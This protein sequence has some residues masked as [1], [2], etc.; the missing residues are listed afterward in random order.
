MSNQRPSTSPELR[1][2]SSRIETVAFDEHGVCHACRY[3]EIKANTNWLARE[4]QLNEL[5]NRHRRTDG[6]YDVIVPGSGGKDSAFVSHVLKHK[7]GMNPL[8]VTWAPHMY[9]D[10]GWKNFQNWLRKGGFDNYLVTP[11]PKVHATLTKL[12]FLNILNPFQPFIIGQKN[13]APRIALHYGIKLIMYG[14]NQAEYH[15]K[16]SETVTPLM[17]RAHYTGRPGE[18]FY[19]GGVH[20]DELPRYGITARDLEPYLPISTEAAERAGIEI[21][22]MSYYHRWVP[23]E[24]FYYAAEHCGFE[25][26]PE[27]SEGTYS[28][29]ASLDDRIDG[30]HYYTMF[31]KFGQGRAM[32]DAAHEIRD[33]HITRE[34]GVALVRK[35][36]GEFPKKYFAE[37]LEYTELTEEEFWGAIDR[38][39]SPHLWEKRDGEWVLKHRV[40]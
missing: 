9:T 31:I 13:L 2:N 25:P 8:T 18:K 28:K 27:R 6:G 40:S 11:N 22:Y 33:G 1:K 19:F 39:R 23:Q 32:N 26:N 20:Q 21:H 34:E 17:S 12:A 16:I 37:F 7:Y 15:N 30:F 14:E 38:N 4:G 3:A 5:L 35:Y 10:I 24:N 36:D 29:Y